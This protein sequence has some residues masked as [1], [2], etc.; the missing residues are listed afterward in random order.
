MASFVSSTA[1]GVAPMS[2]D[3][4]PA[5]AP[6][7]EVSNYGYVKKVI[8]RSKGPRPYSI[9]R[10]DLSESVKVV[11]KNLLDKSHDHSIQNTDKLMRLISAFA[12]KKAVTR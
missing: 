2:W 12:T 5:P 1:P 6:K 8:R 10:R 3:P 4:E 7:Q 11:G 9:P